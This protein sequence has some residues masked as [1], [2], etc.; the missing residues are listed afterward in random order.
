[1][2]FSP[3]QFLGAVAKAVADI[4]FNHKKRFGSRP[5]IFNNSRGVLALTCFII[6]SSTRPAASA[7]DWAWWWLNIL[8]ES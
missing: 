7:S 1:L 6:A 4:H 8:S 3:A 5:A 2:Y